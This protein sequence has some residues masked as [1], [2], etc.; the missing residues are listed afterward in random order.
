[1]ETTRTNNFLYSVGQELKILYM[2]K[3]DQEYLGSNIISCKKRIEYLNSK[4]EQCEEGKRGAGGALR[5]C[6][7][8]DILT[9]DILG[10]MDSID[11]EIA[12]YT[13]KKRFMNWRLDRL[14]TL[15]K[16]PL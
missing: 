6:A 9:D 12:K 14:E 7:G 4:I 13:R 16:R 3:P 11:R 1:M 2:G 5:S 8:S 15:A 10:G